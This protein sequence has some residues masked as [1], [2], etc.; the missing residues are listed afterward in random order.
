MSL[1]ISDLK[2]S[3]G[4]KVIFNGFSYSFKDF[5]AY[6][7]TGESGVGKTTLLRMIAGLD[8]DYSGKISGGGVGK[9][10]FAFQE[11]RLFPSLSALHNVVLANYDEITEDAISKAK[12]ILLALG[13]GDEDMHL[14]PSEL[15]GGMRARI[16]LARAF[17]KDSE[18][19]LLDE[20][21]KELDEANKERVL[22]LIRRES[23]RRL[24]IM[25]T[26]SLYDAERCGAEIIKL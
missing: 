24:V 14:L 2:K 12:K 26:H 19:L 3:F 20:P 25:V 1:I 8:T 18:I 6:A 9:V 13:I 21:S 10:S 17:L 11:H 16:S 7:L 5:G 22:D 23:R 15:S 4:G